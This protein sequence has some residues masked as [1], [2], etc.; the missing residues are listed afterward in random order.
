MTEMKQYLP[1]TF[2][3]VD[4][5]TTDATE[6]KRFYTELFGWRASDLPAG[7]GLVYTLFDKQGKHVC[8]LYQM[9]GDKQALGLPAR[10]SSYLSVASA[11]DSAARAEALGGQVL[12]APFDVKDV[13]RMA[14]LRDPTGAVFS[15]WQPKTYI[16]A[17][18]VNEPGALCWNELHTNDMDAAK[19]FYVGLF[20][21]MAKDG[22]RVVGEEYTAFFNQ[23]R[24]AGGMLPIASEWGQLPPYWSVYFAVDQCD[25]LVE[26]ASGLGARVEVSARDVNSVGRFAVLKDPQGAYFAVIQLLE[27]V[28]A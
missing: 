25:S 5:A 15:I 10:W 3:W 23:D 2:C 7:D 21:W 16:G 1:G 4:L 27:G 8:A 26:R 24:P 17:Q 12:D 22:S 28:V 11:D 20:D 6:A 9:S 14:V 19:R 13:G 18:L